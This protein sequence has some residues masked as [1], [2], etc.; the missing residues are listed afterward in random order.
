MTGWLGAQ[1]S[2]G[3]DGMPGADAGAD[4]G[5]WIQGLASNCFSTA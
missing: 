1:G 4:A 3:P 5:S 2:L